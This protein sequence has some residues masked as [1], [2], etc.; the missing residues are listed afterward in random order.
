MISTKDNRE[1]QIFSFKTRDYYN[2]TE[3]KNISPSRLINMRRIEA[4]IFRLY[5]A[6]VKITNY[7]DEISNYW[8]RY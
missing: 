1:G 6:Q 5:S 2:D 8:D 4:K 7:D 3:Q